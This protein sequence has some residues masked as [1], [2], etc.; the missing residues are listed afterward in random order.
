MENPSQKPT[1]SSK[2]YIMDVLC[3]F[4]I[5]WN[6][7]I[8]YHWCI[9]EQWPYS[10]QDPNIKPE[11]GKSSNLQSP[12]LGLQGYG[13]S[14]QLQNQDREPKFG[15]GVYQRQVTISISISRPKNLVKNLQLH[16]K[17]TSRLRG[18]DF[19][20][21]FKINFNRQNFDHGYTKE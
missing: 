2:A 17:P 15:I 8:S 19:L 7:P 18:Y 5:N 12:K 9:K 16:P 3:T 21:S 6:G 11:S 14:L 13:C 4:K 1:A 10:N 20:P